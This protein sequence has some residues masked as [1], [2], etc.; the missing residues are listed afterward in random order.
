MNIPDKI[1]EIAAIIR[2]DWKNVN[3]AARPYLEA[4]FSLQTISDSCLNDDARSIIN[5]FL[6]NASTWRGDTAREVKKKLK[7][8]LNS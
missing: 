3:Y 6:V 8:L 1:S 4:M 7:S 2:N 5:Y